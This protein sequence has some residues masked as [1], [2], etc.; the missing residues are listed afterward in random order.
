MDKKEGFIIDN[1]RFINRHCTGEDTLYFSVNEDGILFQTTREPEDTQH[2][3]PMTK[4]EWE[5][6][7][8]LIDIQL[9]R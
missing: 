8:R 9:I 2:D 1:A 4:D 3:I 7:K 5:L 6:L